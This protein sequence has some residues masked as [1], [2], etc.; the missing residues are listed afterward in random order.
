MNPLRPIAVASLTI[1]LSTSVHAALINVVNPSFEDTTGSTA[2]FNEF[3]FGPFNGWELYDPDSITG[4]GAGNTFY[5][6]TIDPDEPTNFTAGAP[7][8]QR[9]AIAFNYFGSGDTGEYGLRQ[10]LSEGLQPNTT[11]T[12]EVEIGN[13]ASGTAQNG[14]SFNLDGFPGYRVDLLA[15]GNVV[16]QDNNILAGNIPEGEFATSTVTLTTGNNPVAGMLEIRLVNLNQVDPTAPLAD[17]EVDFDH[18]RLDA[19]P[20]AVPE[21]GGFVVAGLAMLLSLARRRR[22][23]ANRQDG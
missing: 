2:I 3:S 23:R 22:T 7:D 13:I 9:A 8:G 16:A 10:E 1:L 15:G 4:G 12:L 18:V 21:P 6:G 5:V 11:Y 17:L 20:A 14:T 19:S